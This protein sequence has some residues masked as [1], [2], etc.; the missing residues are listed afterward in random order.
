MTFGD[1]VKNLR[2]GRKLSQRELAEVSGISN[3]EISRI[4]TGDRK[5]PSP[6]TLKAI[7][8]YLG[9]TYQEIMQKAGYI[10]EVVEHQGYIENIYRDENGKLMDISRSAKEMYEKDSEWANIAFRVTSADLSEDEINAIKATT[11]AL[12]KQFTKDKK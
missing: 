6:A 4:E 8:P 9:V 5:K 10:E 2:T 1:Y 12:L 3:A 7:A 11:V